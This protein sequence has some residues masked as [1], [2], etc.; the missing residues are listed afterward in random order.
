M[1]LLSIRT[2]I[3]GF[4]ALGLLLSVVSTHAEQREGEAA[5]GLAD[6]I[7]AMD[8]VEYIP[9]E[10]F[11]PLPK[12]VPVR[13]P[14]KVEVVELF[15]YKCPHCYTT[16]PAVEFWKQKAP[17]YIDFHRIPAILGPSW[18]REARVFYT[19]ELLGVLDVFHVA[20]FR[21]IH[22]EK[23]Q[24]STDEGLASFFMRFGVTQDQFYQAFYSMELDNK[25]NKAD[26]LGRQYQTQGVPDFVVNGKYRVSATLPAY[27]KQPL[28]KVFDTI[29]FLAKK[30]QEDLEAQRASAVAK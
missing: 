4:C 24:I 7:N 15:W 21:E 20:F 14:S 22:E 8:K 30:E 27:A 23:R 3:A 2:V 17:D 9:G 28:Q 25:L 29:D 19:A 6:V 26:I 10:H 18:R 16:D 1:Y 12:P 13:D 5:H 11:I